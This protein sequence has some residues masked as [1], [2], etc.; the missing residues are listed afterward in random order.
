M[1]LIS[2]CPR[3]SSYPGFSN[4]NDQKVSTG[5]ES[6]GVRLGVGDVHMCPVSGT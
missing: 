2:K 4:E 1:A 6:I 3:R 5:L